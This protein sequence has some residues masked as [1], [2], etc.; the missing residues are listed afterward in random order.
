MDRDYAIMQQEKE[1]R[2]ERRGMVRRTSGKVA[3]LTF[4]IVSIFDIP[5]FWL[6]I[7]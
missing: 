5:W 3:L 7:Q 2:G 6:V 1:R 4:C